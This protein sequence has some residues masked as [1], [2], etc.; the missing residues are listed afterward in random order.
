[1]CGTIKKLISLFLLYIKKILWALVISRGG[2][3]GLLG[4]TQYL[5][6]INK[7]DIFLVRQL[8]VY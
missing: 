7:Y 5:L 8:E 1:V 6:E 4:V 2:V 3:K